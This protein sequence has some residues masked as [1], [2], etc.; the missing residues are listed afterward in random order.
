MSNNDYYDIQSPPSRRPVG[1]KPAGR[2]AAPKRSRAGWVWAVAGVLAIAFMTLAGCL[3]GYQSAQQ[4]SQLPPTQQPPTV[5]PIQEQF[6][7]GVKDQAEGRYET[8]LQRYEWVLQQ[9]PSYPGLPERI[10]EVMQVL[11]ATAT[12]TPVLPTLTPTVTP[13][14]DLRPIQELFQQSQIL[15][16]NQDWKGTIDTLVT[17][18]QNDRA[19]RMTEVD[20]ML[21]VALRNRGINKI[22]KESD[23]EG[24]IYDLALAERFGPLDAEAFSVRSWARLYII[25]NSFWEAVPEQAV[26]YFEQ[27]AAAAPGLRDASGWSAKERFRSALIQWGDQLLKQGDCRAQDQYER[28][29][30]IRSDADLQAKLQAAL[31]LCAPTPTPTLAPETATPTP[32]PTQPVVVPPSPTSEPP[33]ATPTVEAPTQ[34]PPTPTPTVTP[35]VTAEPTS[36]SSEA[37]SESPAP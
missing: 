2:K 4:A 22:L 11:Y 27:V 29:L 32:T 10:A 35:T 16:S 15:F 8:A 20:G 34:E 24:G 21:Y 26:Y 25:G 30:A 6:E 28:A 37:T 13:T 14:R 36:E 9:N 7:L 31:E 5:D 33:T 19:Y 12:P 17:L 3:A 18:R 23:L 1:S